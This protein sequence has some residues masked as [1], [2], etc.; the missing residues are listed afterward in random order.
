MNPKLPLN[1][2]IYMLTVDRVLPPKCFR[3]IYVAQQKKLRS[4]QKSKEFLAF[5]S[6]SCPVVRFLIVVAAALKSS[7]AQ[8]S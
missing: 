8:H 3:S 7:K 5:S 2:C 6:Q 4:K 1:G